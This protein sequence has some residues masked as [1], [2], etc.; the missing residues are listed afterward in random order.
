MNLFEDLGSGLGSLSLHDRQR[1][2]SEFELSDVLDA[3]DIDPPSDSEISHIIDACGNNR[4][5]FRSNERRVPRSEN[6][7]VEEVTE[8]KT[9]DD[10]NA[11]SQEY[12][13]EDTTPAPEI[14]Y[15][16]LLGILSPTALGARF[17]LKP[18]KLLMPPPLLPKQFKGQSRKSLSVDFE[19][20]TSDMKRFRTANRTRSGSIDEKSEKMPSYSFQKDPLPQTSGNLIK[21]ASLWSSIPQEA[22]NTS[23]NY[24]SGI[25]SLISGSEYPA[26]SIFN[27]TSTTHIPQQLT[28]VHHHHYYPNS[29]QSELTTTYSNEAGILIGRS[30]G[31]SYFPKNENENE[32][33]SI[34]SK[35]HLSYNSFTKRNNHSGL[36]LSQKPKADELLESCSNGAMHP[37][38]PSPWDARATPAERIPYVLLSYL[39][40][41][42]NT[43]LSAFALQML[44]SMVQAV[45]N[46]VSHKMAIE[47]NNLLVEIALC[48]RSYRENHCDPA[49]RVPALEK[50]CDYWDKCMRKNPI[51]IGNRSLIG[52]HTLGVILN[53]LVEPLGLKFLGIGAFFVILLFTCNFGFGYVRARAYYGMKQAHRDNLTKWE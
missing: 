42:T 2:Y 47:T 7:Y 49:E 19:F 9:A 24:A 14:E 16:S 43:L 48:Q 39:Q 17:A 10:L 46:D 34:L 35:R 21:P 23:Y 41:L 8:D 38:L 33:D 32:N 31:S 20:D 25:G 11:I 27:S 12:N 18:Q 30:K 52:A 22:P 5:S 50:M 40:L 45:R 26:S 3:M 36:A 28:V 15:D 53:S 29:K 44:V 51:Q 13:S 6:Y 4:A 37:Y 1:R